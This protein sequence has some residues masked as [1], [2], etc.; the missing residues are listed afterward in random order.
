V[1]INDEGESLIGLEEIA[2][3]WSTKVDHSRG[4]ISLLQNDV[5]SLHERE[6]IAES[7]DLDLATIAFPHL[8][9][10]LGRTT[11][12]YFPLDVLPIRRAQ[13]GDAVSIVGF[14]GQGRQEFET[15]GKFEPFPITLVATSVSDRRVVISEGESPARCGR[16]GKDVEDG[17]E[18]GG[19][20]GSPAIGLN[21]EAQLSLVGVVSEGSARLGCAPPA[22][23]NAP[24]PG[25]VFVVAGV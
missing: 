22:T 10:Q 24:C 9:R 1:E 13:V 20:S 11:K 2:D 17:V 19:F 5:R 21:R 12:Q 25:R 15:F 23:M 8:E 6:V 4:K 16:H 18:L 7:R 14:S 3:P